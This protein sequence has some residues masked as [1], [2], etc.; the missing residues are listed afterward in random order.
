[1]QSPNFHIFHNVKIRLSFWNRIKVLF[2]QPICAQVKIQT[3]DEKTQVVGTKT[4][5]WVE[6]FFVDTTRTW[7]SNKKQP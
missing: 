2:G 4:T 1:M 5:V 7:V 3:N 6:P